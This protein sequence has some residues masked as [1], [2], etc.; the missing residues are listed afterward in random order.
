[1]GAVEDSS[2]ESDGEQDDNEKK[3]REGPNDDGGSETRPKIRKRKRAIQK[4]FKK[5]ENITHDIGG[6]T[7]KHEKKGKKCLM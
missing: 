2:S 5:V 6:R 3:P 4:L 1:M 7:K